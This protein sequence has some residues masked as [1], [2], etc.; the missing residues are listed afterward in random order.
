MCRVARLTV[1]PASTIG[2]KWATGVSVPVRPT[3][4]EIPRT[5][6]VFS[7]A[8]Y[9]N[10]RAQRGDFE[11]EPSSAWRPRSS[12]L[13]TTPSVSKSRSARSLSQ[14]ATTSRT[15]SKV[16]HRRQ[17][18]WVGKPSVRSRSSV[19]VWVEGRFALSATVYIQ[20]AKPRLAVTRE[21]RSRIVPDAAL[22]AL[23]KSG[24][25]AAS[26]SAFSFR[27]AERR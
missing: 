19:S 20:A 2:S 14:A 8:G 21:S 9:L 12:T 22:R 23:A 4:T 15:S 5:T 25:P 18:D 26:R 17:W 13:I 24:S 1:V 3:C 16:E 10:A 11:V 6:V 7:S 27:K